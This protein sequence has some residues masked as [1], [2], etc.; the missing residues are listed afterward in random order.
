[1]SAPEKP[2]KRT[3]HVLELLKKRNEE[4]KAAQESG[5]DLPFPEFNLGGYI[6]KGTK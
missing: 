4:A 5:G 2:A 6:S 3:S 1:V